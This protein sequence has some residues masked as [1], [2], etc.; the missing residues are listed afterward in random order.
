MIRRYAK[1]MNADE[2]TLLR[3]TF[4]Q[5]VPDS[6]E[7]AAFKVIADLAE[8]NQVESIPGQ[9]IG[10]RA[11]DNGDVRVLRA[12]LSRRG[13]GRRRDVHR[14]QMPASDSQPFGEHADRASRLETMIE[15]PVAQKSHNLVVSIQFIGTGGKLP[16]VAIRAVFLLE[17]FL[18]DR[19]DRHRSQMFQTDVVMEREESPAIRAALR[20]DV[21]GNGGRKEP[22][23]DASLH[24]SIASGG[25]AASHSNTPEESGA[26]SRKSKK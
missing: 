7:D 13:D 18:R 8:D 2:Y 26:R 21:T 24:R 9:I 15:S 19:V 16:R 17:E 1:P 20:L 5:Q 14:E 25:E 23:H 6:C 12:A 3:Q 4:G 22:W 11:F 10:K